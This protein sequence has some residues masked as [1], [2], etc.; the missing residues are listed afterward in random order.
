MVE[1][2]FHYPAHI[3]A[4]NRLLGPALDT[5][6]PAAL[7]DAVDAVIEAV[8]VRGGE[9]VFLPGASAGEL[10]ASFLGSSVNLR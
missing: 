1:S 3:D 8:L 5:E 6:D 4:Q 7:D 2:G 10:R 9:V